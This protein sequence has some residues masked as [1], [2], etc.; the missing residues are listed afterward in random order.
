[1]GNR[2]KRKAY[3]TGKM[4]MWLLNGFQWCI[5]SKEANT[6]ALSVGECASLSQ[7]ELLTSTRLSEYTS[8]RVSIKESEEMGP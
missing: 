6:A 1:V 5:S 2:A 8:T 4:L 3:P 7:A